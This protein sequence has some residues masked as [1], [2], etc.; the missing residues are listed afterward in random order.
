MCGA[1]SC[2]GWSI[3]LHVLATQNQRS[4]ELQGF[5]Q[6]CSCLEKVANLVLWGLISVHVWGSLTVGAK[7]GEKLAA[8]R[9]PV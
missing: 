2:G 7:L 6:G 4:G 5:I 9:G 1:G 3:N 8:V